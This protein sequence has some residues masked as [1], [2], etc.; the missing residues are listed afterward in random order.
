M[1]SKQNRSVKK[2]VKRKTTCLFQSKLFIIIVW[3][4][5]F[6]PVT[7]TSPVFSFFSKHSRQRVSLFVRLTHPAAA[8]C[9][10]TN[11]SL[12][13]CL[14]VPCLFVPLPLCPLS[15][16]ACLSLRLPLCFF[17]LQFVREGNR[18]QAEQR[19][20]M[21]D[22]SQGTERQSQTENVYQDCTKCNFKK[23]KILIPK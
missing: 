2:F 9:Q 5:T 8:L 11:V 6:E 20:T 10:S 17:I 3:Q 1:T 18:G 23:T 14:F 12:F 16:F 4:S 22:L 7:Q 21:T 19:D 13:L 15:L